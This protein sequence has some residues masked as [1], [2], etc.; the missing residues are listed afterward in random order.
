MDEQVQ[1]TIFKRLM[2]ICRD[3]RRGLIPL[4]VARVIKWANI[5][6]YLTR[7]VWNTLPDGMEYDARRPWMKDYTVAQVSKI[8]TR[9]LT[10]CTFAAASFR[11]G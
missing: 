6:A 1:G 2:D 4:L 7:E 9:L 10:T 8:A 5:G 3:N 11:A